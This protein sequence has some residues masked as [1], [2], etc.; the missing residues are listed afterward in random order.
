[1]RK[2]NGLFDRTESHI[3]PHCIENRWDCSVNVLGPCVLIECEWVVRVMYLCMSVCCATQCLQKKNWY[4][5]FLACHACDFAACK[6]QVQK[7]ITSS[8]AQ[9]EWTSI[10]KYCENC[11][12]DILVACASEG[13][14]MLECT[15]CIQDKPKWLSYLS[16]IINCWADVILLR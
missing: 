10:E 12:A 4:V 9:G 8:L 14:H 16:R 2:W 7:I 5:C 1:M 15:S 11:V 13:F 3:Q 6:V